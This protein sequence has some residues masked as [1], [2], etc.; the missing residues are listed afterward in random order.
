VKKN[1]RRGPR[2]LII[3]ASL[4]RPTL[5]S[6]GQVDVDG[7]LP[8]PYAVIS[9]TPATGGSVLSRKLPR[10]LLPRPLP[11]VLSVRSL[12][13]ID[14]SQRLDPEP[15]PPVAPFRP[16]RCLQKQGKQ[17]PRKRPRSLQLARRQLGRN[18][19]LGHRTGRLHSPVPPLEPRL[20]PRRG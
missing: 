3:N 2:P 20:G 12:S 15:L 17:R 1:T 4:N 9:T 13:H 6:R 19:S 10:P 8:R 18:H 5:A 11:L 7:S 16:P 14:G